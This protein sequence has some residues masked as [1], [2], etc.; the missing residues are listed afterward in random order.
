MHAVRVLNAGLIRLNFGGKCPLTQDDWTKVACLQMAAADGSASRAARW[1]KGGYVHSR[2]YER[3][4]TAIDE[5]IGL[6]RAHIGSSVG[7]I[8]AEARGEYLSLSNASLPSRPPRP[9]LLPSTNV[10]DA[11]T[12]G[13]AR[14]R[15]RMEVVD[16]ER[17]IKRSWLK[18][19]G[20]ASALRL[21]FRLMMAVVKPEDGV[22]LFDLARLG[23]L[24]NVLH[25]V[26]LMNDG[27]IRA[28]MKSV[29]FTDGDVD[30]VIGKVEA[31]TDRQKFT[32]TV[33]PP[34]RPQGLPLGEMQSTLRSML[35]SAPAP[36]PAMAVLVQDLMSSE[37]SAPINEVEQQ[38]KDLVSKLEQDDSLCLAFARLL[39]ACASL[40][41]RILSAIDGDESSLAALQLE[42][43]P[44][45]PCP[46]A[47]QEAMRVASST[48]EV[49]VQI[50]GRVVSAL[51][52]SGSQVGLVS[53]SV[54]ETAGWKMRPMPE[55]MRSVRVANGSLAGLLGAVAMP[56][57]ILGVCRH[58][59]F[60][61]MDGLSRDMI[62]GL[63]GI[64]D[65]GIALR[66]GEKGMWVETAHERAFF[67][68]DSR[69]AGLSLN[70]AA[71]DEALPDSLKEDESIPE[72]YFAALG[73]DF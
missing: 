61:V 3:L 30:K 57:T 53:R 23:N 39:P 41:G 12:V 1:K 22:R 6:I 58:A 38:A 28:A 21:A 10:V 2:Q 4:R 24:R 16:G 14:K 7:Y 8:V 42:F 44:Q 72:G 36:P 68:D 17:K 18:D 46:P 13:P 45:I 49:P 71:V 64:Q 5:F 15:P 73:V 65:F 34:L 51:V 62:I 31:P 70:S 19:L 63:N 67:E 52:D 48:V 29:G 54:C 69:F 20:K 37:G 40:V 60:F 50:G 66:P 47:I 11:L 25:Q 33:P 55:G 9:T 35:S 56:V 43:G 59:M 32:R 27:E 26:A